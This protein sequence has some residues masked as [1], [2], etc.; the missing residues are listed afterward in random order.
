MSKWTAKRAYS[1]VL[2]SNE[3]LDKLDEK[4]KVVWN[5]VRDLSERN[6]ITMPEVGIYV[7]TDPN[8]FAT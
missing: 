2:I 1:I 3:N 5:V 6:H 4:E 8:A 7:D